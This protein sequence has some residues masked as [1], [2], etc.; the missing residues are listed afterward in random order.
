[1]GAGLAAAG[2]TLCPWTGALAQS[3][4]SLMRAPKQA[5]VI[6]NS[7]YK[8]APL[9]N[10]P[11]D[12]KGM[13]AA[14]KAM[15]FEVMLG[16]EMS[17]AQM[18]EAIRAY[19]SGLVKAKAVGLFYFAGHGMQ[20]AWRNYLVPVDAE[21]TRVEQ[22]RERAVD[23]NSLIEGI[24]KAGN[25]MNIIILDA[26]RDDP[27]GAAARSDQKGLSQLDAPPHT[28][29]AYATAPG[30]TAA[31]GEGANGLYT[32]NLLRELKVPEA[33]IEDVFK[34]VRLNVRLRSKGQQIPWESTSLE[35][36][37]WFIPPAQVRKLAEA[38]AERE[39]QQELALWE[40]IKASSEP[41]PL[42][43]Y[44]RRHPSGKFSE[45]A[46][47]RLDQ[48]LARQGERKVRIE[49]SRE[50]PYSKG[51]AVADTNRKV[52]DSYSYRSLDLYTKQEIET[53]TQTIMRITETEILYDDGVITDLLGNELYGRDGV[54]T[55]GN[56]HWGIDYF[57]G[58]RWASRGNL[59]RKG[60]LFARFEV[61]LRVV[62]RETIKVPAGTFDAFVIETNGWARGPGVNT[63]VYSKRWLAPDQV[64]AL[65]ALD[66]LRK[67]GSGRVIRSD[68]QELLSY[69]Q[70]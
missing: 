70:S 30:N 24:R 55:S 10:P 33:R 21:I 52:G 44:L 8:H 48:V 1:M 58:K 17:H 63:Q 35:E 22:V 56:Q 25:P 51:T 67:A 32:E 57:I 19:H 64:R 23:V 69:R 42:E 45:L 39:F 13:A 49:S 60:E 38:E 14:L 15:G 61:D 5:L 50:N 6:G 9:Q 31:D 46:Q 29:L 2:T 4:S 36:D 11:N 3:G 37:F 66:T 34:R 62:A 54:S 68:R 47:L 20:L 40:K 27:F 16:L 65:I 59:A 53:Y 43:D 18:S 7:R 26:C 28:L 12:A 41:Q